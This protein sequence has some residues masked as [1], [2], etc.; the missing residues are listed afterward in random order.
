MRIRSEV[1]VVAKSLNGANQFRLAISGEVI[2]R[3]A[4][5]NL[6]FSFESVRI[7]VNSVWTLLYFFSPDSYS[8]HS[9]FVRIRSEV[10]VVVKSLNGANQFRLAISGKS[11]LMKRA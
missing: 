4:L 8:R 6:L 1:A 10:A 11:Y 5:M 3:K 7:E 2:F 9:R